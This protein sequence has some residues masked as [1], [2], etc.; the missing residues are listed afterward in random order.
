MYRSFKK[1][2]EEDFKYDLMCIPWD[3]IK[4]FDD[5]DDA[6]ETWY[7]LFN[8]VLDKNVP[9]KQHRVKRQN[10]PNWLTPEIIDVMKVRDR[11]KYLG[12]EAQ[13]KSARN[14][15]TNLI[16]VSKK[17]HYE[18]LIDNSKQNPTNVW[19]IFKE[20]GCGKGKNKSTNIF[21]IKTNDKSF[22]N[23]KDIANEFNH[24]FHFCC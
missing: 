22:D 17:K 13:Y 2:N 11:L 16:K 6:I 10:Q 23:S 9:L 5:I 24:F 4:V 20:F 1:F 19:K 21:T 14:I 18:K 12:D 3:S 15:V 7:S 8:E